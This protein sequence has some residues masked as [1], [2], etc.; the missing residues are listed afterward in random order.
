MNYQSS[1][2]RALELGFPSHRLLMIS[3]TASIDPNGSTLHVGDP[4]R[5]I[6]RTLEVVTALLESRSMGW[7]DAIRGIAYFTNL[8]DEPLYAAI[9]RAHAIPAFPLAV[10]HAG[11]CR[12]ELLFELEID[13][14]QST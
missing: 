6:E 9:C 11:I 13:A 7:R 14:A 8:R 10:A 12:R 1:F 3:G 4:A 2:S 5:Q